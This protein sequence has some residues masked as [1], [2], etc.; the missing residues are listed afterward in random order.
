M[1]EPLPTPIL[2]ALRAAQGRHDRCAEITAAQALIDPEIAQYEKALG[3][4][5]GRH[6]DLGRELTTARD[7]ARRY[8]RMAV[9]LAG[10]E[11]L[12]IPAAL[13]PGTQAPAQVPPTLADED[14]CA[15][16]AHGMC[17]GDGCECVCHAAAALGYADE[18]Q[19]AEAIHTAGASRELPETTTPDGGEPP[20]GRFHPAPEDGGESDA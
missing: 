13:L 11:H 12:T 20:A 1:T 5:R 15:H 18:T 4:L 19:R 2:E 17:T 6:A 9:L 14:P 10:E 8:L 3:E 16:G 7:D